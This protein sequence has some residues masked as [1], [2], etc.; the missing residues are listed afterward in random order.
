MYKPSHVIDWVF[1]NWVSIFPQ[2]IL[3]GRYTRSQY[4]AQADL[5]FKIL[6]P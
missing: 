5:K 6:F 4:V 3:K 2:T 1:Q